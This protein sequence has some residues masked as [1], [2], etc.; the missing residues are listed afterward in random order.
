MKY[1]IFDNVLPEDIF[2][3][4]K[5]HIISLPWNLSDGL[6][7]DNETNLSNYYFVH[8]F[9]FR[10]TLKSN[11]FHVLDPILEILQPNAIFRIKANLYTYTGSFIEHPEHEDTNFDCKNAIFYMDNS[12]GYTGIGTEKIQSKE[13]RLAIMERMMHFSTNCSDQKFRITINFNYF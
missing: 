12:N 5:Q 4:L 9:L 2:N 6:V 3:T 10:H 1:K 11:Y 13:N 7:Y 8:E